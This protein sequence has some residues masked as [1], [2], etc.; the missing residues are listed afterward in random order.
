MGL[1]LATSDAPFGFQP[2]GNVLRARWYAIVTEYATAVFPGDAMEIGGTAITTARMGTLQNAQVEETGAAGSILGACLALED[3]DG[4]PVG[5]I[6]A[7]TVG[8]GTVA[9][10]A[11][12]ADHPQQEYV[13]QEDGDTSSI[14]VA[15]IGLN[16]EGISTHA[17]DTNTNR[18]K[19]ELDSS[20]VAT[21]ATLAW[22]V[23]GVHPDD[24]ISA[25]GAA[26]NYCRFIVMPNSAHK[27]AN[28]VGA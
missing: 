8:D 23:I 27:A 9:G 20:S 1:D 13:V 26:G 6:A 14:V 17:G 24:T 2:F 5:S 4:V 12:I 25:A 22:K 11:L 28:V 7:S 10:Y 19:M 3:S 16:A 18:S 21:T 15:N